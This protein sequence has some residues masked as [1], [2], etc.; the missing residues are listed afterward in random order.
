M[1]K[2]LGVVGSPRKGGN[3]ELLVNEVLKAAAL[4]GAKTETI[5]LC[6]YKL[7]PCNGCRTCFETKNCAITDD[8]EKLF[9]KVADADALVLGS[10]VYFGGVTAQVKGFIDRIGYL[11]MA[12]ER[13][14]LLNR[15]GASAV[16]GRRTGMLNA[17]LEILTFLTASRMIVPSGGRLVAVGREK[18]DVLKDNEGME[19]ARDLGARIVELAE[20]TSGFRKK[21]P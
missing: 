4:K 18:G 9:R 2:V 20:A 8:V 11:N 15:V 14:P 17:S 13:K 10:P 19:S 6:D 7:A 3:T 1:V 12:R 16:V 5:S 21:S